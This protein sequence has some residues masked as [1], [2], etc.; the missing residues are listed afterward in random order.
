MS[1]KKVV[2]LPEI[3]RVKS[4]YYLP[5]RIHRM[6]MTIYII[7]F[8]KTHTNKKIRTSKFIRTNLRFFPLQTIKV[9][10]FVFQ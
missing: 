2:L 10:P 4:F 1:Q 5:V 7:C 8:K 3:G 9:G 6:C